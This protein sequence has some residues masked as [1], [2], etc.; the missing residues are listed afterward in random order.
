[1]TAAT[2]AQNAASLGNLAARATA[3]AE[4]L[5]KMRERL[6]LSRAEDE[7]TFVVAVAGAKACAVMCRAL[8]RWVR[9]DLDD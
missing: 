4:E 2:P 3:L 9:R 7:A 6:A 1:M 5:K 8:E